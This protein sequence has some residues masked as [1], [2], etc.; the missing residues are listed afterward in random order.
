[1]RPAAS[2]EVPRSV[3]ALSTAWLT[4]ALCSGT[5]GA[6]VVGFELSGTH[7]GTSSGRALTVRYNGAGAALPTRLFTKTTPDLK[8]KLFTGLTNLFVGEAN[9][10]NLIR[11]GLDIE[12]PAGY[13]ASYE[14]RSCRSMII[15]EDVAR[16]RGATFGDPQTTH[17]EDRKSVV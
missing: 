15:L 12:C 16:T 3:A 8:T 10:Y 14:L 11:P 2:D 17:V 7:E 5:P 1:M 13:H 6:E 4:R 9:F